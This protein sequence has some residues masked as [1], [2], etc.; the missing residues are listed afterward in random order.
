[1]FT[2]DVSTLTSKAP[3]QGPPGSTFYNGIVHFR[4]NVHNSYKG[5]LTLTLTLHIFSSVM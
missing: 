2:R 1:M 5:I 4:A 3:L